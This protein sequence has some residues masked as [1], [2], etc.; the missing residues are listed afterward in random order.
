MTT[1]AFPTFARALPYT[2]WEFGQAPNTFAH[3]SPL[4][5]QVQTVEMPGTRWVHSLRLQGLAVDERQMMSVFFAQLRGRGNRYTLHDVINP[6]PRGTMR[7]SLTT[8]GSIT[9]G[10]V[11]CSVTGGAGQASTTLLRGDKLSIGGELKIITADATANGSGV[12]ALTVEPPFRAAVTGGAAVVWDKPTATFMRTEDSWRM[13]HTA[14]RHGD[15]TL[16]GV[17][18]FA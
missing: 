18:A 14:P 3:M 11:T 9:Q 1:I 17:E 10:A 15:I 4:S 13:G 2:L 12:I 16:D 5:G 7:G 8:S 6:T